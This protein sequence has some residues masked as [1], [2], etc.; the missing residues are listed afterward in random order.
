MLPK[1]YCPCCG[2]RLTV[3]SLTNIYTDE[4]VVSIG[5]VHCK[6]EIKSEFPIPKEQV[7]EEAIRLIPI[8]YRNYIEQKLFPEKQKVWGFVKEE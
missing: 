5:C 1:L 7:Y 3:G 8:F 2:S 6:K 4:T